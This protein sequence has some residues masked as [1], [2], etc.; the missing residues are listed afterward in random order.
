M[1]RASRRW[2]LAAAAAPAV[3]RQ[4]TRLA[5]PRA[6]LQ[7]ELTERE[8]Y[9][10]TDPAVLHHLPRNHHRFVARNNSF[11]VLA[12]EHGGSRQ[13]YR[14][15]LRRHRLTQLTEGNDVH[16]YAAHLRRN[17]R[18]LLY[19]QGRDLRQADLNGTN[20]RTHYSCPEGW[21]L[22]GDLDISV[23]ERY[24]ALIEMRTADWRPTPEQ[25][26]ATE[27]LCR[28]RIIDLSPASS[29]KRDWVAVEER[30]WLSSPRFRPWHSQV[31]YAREGPREQVR[32]RLQLTGLDG[33]GRASVRP[34]K[35]GERLLRAY[36]TRDGSQLRYVHYPD[37][38]RWRAAIRSLR[39]ETREERIEAPC[40]AF[41]WLAENADGSAI[42][43]ASR[44]PSGPNLYVLFPKMRREITLGEHASSLRPHPVAGTDRLDRFAAAPEPS[45]SPNSAWLYF[46]TDREGLPAVYAMPID[47][48]VEETSAA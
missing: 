36:W 10:L 32:R 5:A 40:S 45:L 35:G 17:D 8:L 4:G 2:F 48:L 43:G 7:D 27:P 23:G 1:R 12:G 39:P 21:L 24:A 3:A 6:N 16:P 14:L 41:G 37:A 20:R 47:D 26:F 18:A 29:R 42:V 44:R 38:N 11:L 28:L 34:T 15:D 19:L 46:V 13:L 33:T 22:T 25:Q 30:R 31:L 9:R